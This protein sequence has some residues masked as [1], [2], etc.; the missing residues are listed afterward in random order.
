MLTACGRPQGSQSHEDMDEEG[1]QK[2]DFL[3]DII[4][5]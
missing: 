1:D 4:N 5:G 2:P 3:V